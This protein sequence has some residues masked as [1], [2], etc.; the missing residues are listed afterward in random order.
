MSAPF[1]IPFNFQ[2]SSSSRGTTASYTVPAGKYALVTITISHSFYPSTGFVGAQPITTLAESCH[3]NGFQGSFDIWMKSGEVLS[4]SNTNT[5][6]SAS[7][8]GN[9]SGIARAPLN[10]SA[11]ISSGITVNTV[12]W[13][14]IISR[15]SFSLVAYAP[16]VQVFETSSLSISMTCESSIGWWAQEYNVIS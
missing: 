3:G 6:G 4:L 9:T 1:V 13:R 8:S 5:N 16:Q 14:N 15:A 12:L 2:P 11:N 7:I 10:A